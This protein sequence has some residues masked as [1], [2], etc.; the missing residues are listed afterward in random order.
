MPVFNDIALTI[1]RPTTNATLQEW[2]STLWQ[3]QWQALQHWL[4][5]AN[6]TAD[7]TAHP[8][9]KALAAM[10]SA[11]QSYYQRQPQ[12]M[13]T[14]QHQL[15]HLLDCP[16]PFPMQMPSDLHG[17]MHI[18]H[19]DL[20]IAMGEEKQLQHLTEICMREAIEK[21]DDLLFIKCCVKM[22]MSLDAQNQ[23]QLAQ[24]YAEEAVEKIAQTTAYQNTVIAC[25]ALM[26][27]SQVLLKRQAYHKIEVLSLQLLQISRQIGY[28]E[29]EVMA[30]CDLAVVRSVETDYAAAMPLL[31]ESLE[32]SQRIGYRKQA[33]NCLINIG[34]IYAQLYNYEDALDRY[35]TAL[36]EYGDTLTEY[37]RT[38]LNINIGNIHFTMEQPDESL[39]YLQEALQ[40]AKQQAQNELEAQILALIARGHLAN[41]KREAAQAVTEEAQKIFKD[42]GKAV[43]GRQVHRLNLAE[44]QIAERLAT[45]RAYS[46]S[47]R[48]IAA[49]YRLRDDASVLR[50]YTL[51]AKIF[52]QRGAFQKAFKC[53]TI[54]AREQAEN[55]KM[56]RNRQMLD[57]E[58]KHSLREKQRKIEQLTKENQLQALLIEQNA[59]IAK[60]NELLLQVNAELQQFAYVT[61]HD[62]KEPLR[63][64]GSF[65]QIIQDRYAPKLDGDAEQYFRYISEGVGRMNNLLDALLQYATIGKNDD[66]IELVSMNE[67]VAIALDNLRLKIIETDAQIH[68]GDLPEVRGIT[69]L[70]VQLIQ[71]L[72][73]NALKFRQKNLAPI[74]HLSAE[75]KG[76]EWLF[77]ISDNGIGIAEEHQ[78]QIFVIFQ[79]LHTRQQYDGTGIGLSIC[80]KIVQ[81]F[82]GRISVR[83]EVNKGA[84][85]LFTL[86]QDFLD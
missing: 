74:I 57:L 68:V 66:G 70:L 47:V 76:D 77:S 82:G 69:S 60:Q 72:L 58:I 3:R 79:R 34:T 28:A 78:E 85:F 12:A 52:A 13:Q 4:D 25:R 49:A 42:L 73:A 23:S 40:K 81:Q 29:G 5:H 11:V 44:L 32:K 10:N 20:L 83:S 80:Q 62:L 54:V 31:L 71:N 56:R 86:P 33:A 9:V 64:I 36:S 24:E 1:Q 8:A 6:P 41:G 61:S 2:R 55:D 27:L 7:D 14:A 16:L 15:F 51:M 59:Q 38:A 43:V 30:L 22:S 17:E 48:G 37:T 67:I 53:Q 75:A 45:D 65:S 35:R 63:M 50:G 19:G 39:R 46:L 26:Q 18:T 84:T 21:N